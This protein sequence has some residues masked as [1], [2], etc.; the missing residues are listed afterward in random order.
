[1]PSAI[2]RLLS[3]P[4]GMAREFVALENK[5]RPEWFATCDPAG[6]KLG[7]GGGTAHLLAEAWRDTANG[8]SF[9]TWLNHSRK[10]LIHGGGQSRRL[11]SYAPVGKLLMPLPAF[12][13]AYGQRLDQ[14]LLD[15]Q[16]PDYER[17]L[18]HAGPKTVAMITSGD[19]LLRFDRELPPFPDVDVLG[20][21]MWV[22]AEKAKDFGVFFSPRKN[23][24]K[25]AFFLQKP[26][27]ARTRELAAEFLPL[28]DTGMWLLSERAVRVLMSK[29]GWDAN[30]QKFGGAT[31]SNYELYA[32]FGLSLGTQPA[33]PDP[34]ISALTSAVIPLPKAEFYHFGT[35]Q[36]LIESVAALQ[37]IELDETKLGYAGAKR[38]PDQFLQNTKF[39]FPLRQEENHTLWVENSTVPATWKLAHEHVLTGV[40]ENA[41][42][43]QLEA[44]VCLDFVPVGE[45]E[46]A[47]RPYGF[48]DTFSGRFGDLS[49][50]WF[51]RSTT[52][53]LVAR[54]LTL[55]QAGVAKETDIQQAALF[56]V[57]K[58]EQ[59]NARFLEWMFA[60]KPT[61]SPE[62]TQLWLKSLRLSAQ[63]IAEQANLGRLY[64]QRETHRHACLA[65]ML[66]NGRW[67]V[68]YRL[69]LQHTA[70]DFARTNVALPDSSL[71][72]GDEPLNFVHDEMFRAAVLRERNDARWQQHEAK[73]FALLREMIIHEAQ[74]KLA[75]PRASIQEDQIVWGRSPVR[76]DLAGGWTDTP[77]HCLE[78]GGKVLN[79]GVNLNGQP[80]IQVFA[81]LCPRP[82]L[83][84]RS[85]DLGVEQ[86]VKTFEE[87]DTFAQPGSEFALAK[88]AFALAGFLP[89]F[90]SDSG[91]RSLEEQLKAFGGGIEVSMLSAVPKGS[92]LGTSSILAATL[93]ATLAD[94]C[95]LG[96]D[97]H[98]LFQR[99]L[100]MEQMLTTGGGWQDQAGAIFGGVKLI[101]TSAGLAQTPN[102]RW[103]PP[104]LFGSGQANSTTLLYYTGLT[105]LAKNILAEIVRGMFLNSPNHLRILNEIGV[106]A[107]RCFN[108]IQRRDRA[109]LVASVRR[110]WEL[111]QALD[112]GTNT[113][114]VGAILN[115]IEP[116][117]A[118][119]KLLGAG[120]GGFVLIFAKDE[121]AA[122]RIK[123]ELTTNP[124]NARAR[125]VEMTLS[126][127]GL[128]LTRS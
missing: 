6:S 19:V 11:P 22:T 64:Q 24:T 47:V 117:T 108:A 94:L 69:D 97:R 109:E 106:N 114:E 34:E 45:A 86:R 18:A 77:P 12:R 52:E 51:G 104:H 88:A 40:P 128:E 10:L 27:P 73:A 67:S 100:A 17:V 103:L 79:L 15:V 25:L 62:H 29:C 121:V 98:T 78:H 2:Q 20:L 90:S 26:E 96:W 99:T 7:S 39:K 14:T 92:G 81:K 32:Q 38:H 46:F 115:R 113:P 87:L 83:V 8:N 76:L 30:A 95:G 127:Q 21:G 91:A 116:W 31:A 53:W 9:A 1:M 59:L 66:R 119:C 60:A 80:P 58:L 42:D 125:F 4:P 43:L 72:Q 56:P 105:R 84:L 75:Q 122:G 110:S 23:P 85:I 3:L 68:F 36:Q 82:E 118:A 70:R 54:Q 48:S 57:L 49:T 13:W 124:P 33:Q 37:N 28:V 102:V 126:E 35:S 50:K 61:P 101:E 44:G 74:L 41:W 93:L 55:S 16:L 63:Q 89:R 65:P 107:E 111:N 120:G 71:K 5:S 112:A 123:H